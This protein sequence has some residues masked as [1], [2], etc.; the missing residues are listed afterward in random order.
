M[1][2][3]FQRLN[4]SFFY[5]PWYS[6]CLGLCHLSSQMILPK[7]HTCRSRWKRLKFKLFSSFL[8]IPVLIMIAEIYVFLPPLII[9][10]DYLWNVF[11]SAIKWWY[12]SGFWVSGVMRLGLDS[13]FSACSF[14]MNCRKALGLGEI[15]FKIRFNFFM[16]FYEKNS[17]NWNGL[18]YQRNNVC[19]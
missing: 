5:V 15:R 13:C 6:K 16:K 7:L 4:N 3:Q 2:L 11:V 14:I 8:Q 18:T 17:L 9:T 12:F 19:F 1:F 10:A